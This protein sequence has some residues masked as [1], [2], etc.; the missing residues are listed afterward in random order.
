MKKHINRIYILHWLIILV[1]CLL[2]LFM[3][4]MV[5]DSESMSR[6]WPIVTAGGIIASVFCNVFEYLISRITK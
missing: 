3:L 1:F 5:Y 4:S 6:I 2:A